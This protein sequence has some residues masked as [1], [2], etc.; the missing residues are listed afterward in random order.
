MQVIQA[1]TIA[2]KLL[3]D[4]IKITDTRFKQSKSIK[5]NTDDNFKTFI[6]NWMKEKSKRTTL[7][8]LSYSCINDDLYH[9][10]VNFGDSGEFNNIFL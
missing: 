3:K 4:K 10:H 6:E 2:F 7:N 1:Q 8:I 9:F 5:F